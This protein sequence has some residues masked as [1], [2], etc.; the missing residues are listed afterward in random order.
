LH[1]VGSPCKQGL[2][3]TTPQ[4]VGLNHHRISTTTACMSSLLAFHLV[5]DFSLEV[6]CF[7]D[8]KSTILMNKH[9]KPKSS[10]YARKRKINKIGGY[11]YGKIKSPPEY[12]YKHPGIRSKY[13]K[14]PLKFVDERNN[15]NAS[16]SLQSQAPVAFHE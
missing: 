10:R 7:L 12:P 1:Q 16:R 4:I 15:N 9:V 13:I 11:Y 8:A 2:G 5:S 6:F 3:S 14:N